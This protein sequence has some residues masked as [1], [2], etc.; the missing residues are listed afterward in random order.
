MYVLL[1]G[2]ICTEAMCALIMFT[3][4]IVHCIILPYLA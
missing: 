4:A 1:S 3:R 2:D